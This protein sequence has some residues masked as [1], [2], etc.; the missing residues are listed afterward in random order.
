MTLAEFGK[1]GDQ[2]DRLFSE[3]ADIFVLQHCHEITPP[4]RS[5]VRAFAQ[6]IGR[7]RLFCVIDGYDTVR[8]LEAYGK[9]GFGSTRPNSETPPSAGV[10]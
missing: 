6:Q 9:C 8:L 5:T 4:V 2:I 10:S 7:L 3:P 1:N